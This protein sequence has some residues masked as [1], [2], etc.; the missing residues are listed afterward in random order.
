MP[1]F[2]FCLRLGRVLCLSVLFLVVLGLQ[3]ACQL[4]DRAPAPAVCLVPES[5]PYPFGLVLL[6]PAA[7]P[8]LD[9]KRLAPSDSS[10]PGPRPQWRGFRGPAYHGGAWPRPVRVLRD[11]S[12][13]VVHLAK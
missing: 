4:L 8:D 2:S 12:G 7:F 13:R 10:R 3:R 9:R 11:S 5:Q 6:R 1:G